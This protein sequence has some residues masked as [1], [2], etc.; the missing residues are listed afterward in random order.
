[1]QINTYSNK[2]KNINVLKISMDNKNIVCDGKL[3][4]LHK[5][6]V[7]CS[8]FVSKKSKFTSTL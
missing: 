1:M 7:V 6:T 8:S 4:T 5:T 2:H 3:N